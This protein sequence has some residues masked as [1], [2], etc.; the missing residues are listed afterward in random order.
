MLQRRRPFGHAR[1]AGACC[2]LSASFNGARSPGRLALVRRPAVQLRSWLLAAGCWLLAAGCW[3]L[4]A[5]CWLLAAG[6]W[7]LAAKRHDVGLRPQVYRCFRCATRL[8]PMFVPLLPSC[9]GRA[10]RPTLPV[11]CMSVCVHRGPA[12][13]VFL[14]EGEASGNQHIPYATLVWRHVWSN[15]SKVPPDWRSMRLPPCL[16]AL[17]RFP[18]AC[19]GTRTF[20]MFCAQTTP[21]DCGRG[22]FMCVYVCLQR[23]PAPVRPAVSPRTLPT[24]HSHVAAKAVWLPPHGVP[25][26]V[27]PAGPWSILWHCGA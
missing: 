13:Q 15:S 14:P 20:R 7:L 23:M 24:V 12:V 21:C 4:A 3:L 8:F 17:S 16:I 11:P 2:T 19:A 10:C 26:A 27:W 25:Y 22:V 6:C 9:L 5:G 1:A 18:W